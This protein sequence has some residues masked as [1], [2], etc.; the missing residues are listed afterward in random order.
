[1]S[2]VLELQRTPGSKITL[3]LEIKANTEGGFDETGRLV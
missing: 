3:T 1:V 2:I